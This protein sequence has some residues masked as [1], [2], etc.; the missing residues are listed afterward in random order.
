[1]NTLASNLLP[2]HSEVNGDCLVIPS[3]F[4]GKRLYNLLRP[5]LLRSMSTPLSSDAFTGFGRHD[6]RGW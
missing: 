4:H 3:G 5:E 2:D 1:V 6:F